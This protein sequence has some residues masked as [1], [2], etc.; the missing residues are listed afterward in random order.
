MQ[1]KYKFTVLFLTA[2]F[3]AFSAL[4]WLKPA[5]TYSV[6]ERRKLAQMP[7]LSAK[8]V[9]DVAFMT[10][11]EEY[12]LDQFPF[13]ESFRRMKAWVSDNVFQK[14]DNN[15]IYVA[16]GYAVKM[17][18]P[19]REEALNHAGKSFQRLYDDYL[20]DRGSSI[21]LSLIPDKNYFLAEETGHLSMNYETFVCAVTERM[22]YA[23]YV[24][25]MEALEIGDYYKT[26]IH[27][28]QEQ[29]VDGAKKLAAAMN[30]QISGD[31]EINRLKEPF[32]G[33]YFGQSALPLQGE[34]L[35]YLTNEALDGCVV[36]NYETDTY[37][38]IYD[39]EKASGND[40]Y[41]LFLSGP[42]SL[43][44]IENPNA[45]TDRELIV[46]RDSFGSSLIPLLAEGYHKITLIDIRYMQSSLLE[47]YMDFTGQD[48]LF[49]Y[50]TTVLNHGETL[51]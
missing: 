39:P 12:A 49:L 5:H 3:F 21:Y 47:N 15:E 10:K 29:I 20:K 2:C 36:Y 1:K 17:E 11:F 13:R 26:D 44:T 28:R 25:L 16:D 35:C 40:P 41:E 48:V 14:S 30:V 33:V 46:F 23:E 6:T 42:V 24:D 45:H 27:W 7:K 34:E 4:C 18:Y 50:S 37:G 38:G 43:M 31:Y 19:F 8:T 32:Y 51:K 9:K 22:P